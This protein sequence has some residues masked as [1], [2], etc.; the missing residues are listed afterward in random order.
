MYVK[1]EEYIGELSVVFEKHD[2]DYTILGKRLHLSRMIVKSE[3]RGRGYAKKL[4]NHV[5]DYAK[6]HNYEELSLGVNLDNYIALR[7]YVG[8]GFTK[9]QYIG[10]DPDGKFLKLI[11]SLR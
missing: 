9:I 5:I 6:K 11:K 4:I 2:P 3:L 1:D 8:L 10:E 7:L